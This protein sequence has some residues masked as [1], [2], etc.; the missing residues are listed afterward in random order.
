ML[1]NLSATSP[2]L[3]FYF[4]YSWVLIILVLVDVILKGMALWQAGR[5][6]QKS[7]FVALFLLNTVGVLPIIYLLFFKKTPTQ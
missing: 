6:N 4:K 5:N 7:W 3:D 2:I 1:S